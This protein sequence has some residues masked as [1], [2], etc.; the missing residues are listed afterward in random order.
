MDAPGS[1]DFDSGRLVLYNIT[2]A[3]LISWY[4]ERSAKTVCI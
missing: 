1:S 3:Y 2:V 4:K